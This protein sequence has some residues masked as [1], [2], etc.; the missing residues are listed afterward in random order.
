MLER[1]IDNKFTAQKGRLGELLKSIHELVISLNNDDIAKVVFAQMQN[2][3]EPFRF[4]VVGEVKAGKSSFIN[5]LLGENI[6]AVHARPCT[7]VIEKL[8]Y[9]P[10]RSETRLSDHLI[11]KTLPVDILKTI[12]IVDTP[13]TNT[14]IENHQEI[15]EHYLPNS[16]LIIFVFYAPNPYTQTAWSLL[17]LIQKEWRKQLLLVM[18]QADRA[19][20]EEI[21]INLAEL[22]AQLQQEQLAAAPI[23]V[24]SAKRELAG[25][26]AAADSG[27]A[28]VREFIR[29][30]ITGGN[31]YRLKLLS[32]HGTAQRQLEKVAE[33]LAEQRA[34]LAQ[35]QATVHKV[36]DRLARSG[37]Q[38]GREIQALID[39]VMRGYE[40]LC[41]DLAEEFSQGLTFGALLGRSVRA[42]W[43]RDSSVDRWIA[44]MQQ[45]FKGRV[46]TVVEEIAKERAKSFVESVRK[47][48]TE[49][50]EEIERIGSGGAR[51]HDVALEDRRVEVLE[52]VR[53]KVTV[54]LQ[55]DSFTRLLEEN[56]GGIMP[57]AASG[58]ALA[59]VGGIIAVATNVVVLDITAGL[60]SAAGLT[61][62]G[63]VLIFKRG[64]IGR[65]FREGL[66][67]GKK[68]FEKDIKLKLVDK[69]NV[70]YEQIDGSFAEFYALVERRELHLKP[71]AERLDL[72]V[73]ESKELEAS[74]GRG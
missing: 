4:V 31:H 74:L 54:L 70:I 20:P 60:L 17:R 43:R 45:R 5:A 67:Q 68:Q 18:Q 14:V 58:T 55:D 59:V 40:E 52:D 16:D 9:G 24:T 21:E 47:L 23:F 46:S 35:D 41:N 63:G 8:D 25:P 10:Q 34:A 50:R 65:E 38:S 27:F 37:R 62:A 33:S 36:R 11:Q 71:I 42:L 57:L 13:G 22:R 32:I 19:T 29:D 30:T 15:T 48:L 39:G 66:L 53:K 28:A 64:R 6:C 3:G 2:L 51:P 72:I 1:L 69:L 56:P 7:A 44:D 73:K 49:L 26:P 61:L 12:S